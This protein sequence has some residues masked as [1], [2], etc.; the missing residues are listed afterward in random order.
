MADR[1]C[2]DCGDVMPAK[3]KRCA[4]GW[5]AIAETGAIVDRNHQRCAWE[6]NGMRCRYIGTW[7]RSTLG[8]GP[9]FCRDHSG[10]EDGAFGHRILE[11]SFERMPELDYT[12]ENLW[13]IAREWYLAGAS[14]LAGDRPKN[15]AG[16]GKGKPNRDWARR[17]MQRHSSGERMPSIALEF[18]RE[19]L[20]VIVDRE[21]ALEREAIMA[22]GE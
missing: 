5:Q 17:V 6:S 21:A 15:L 8:G 1:H 19:V 13:R 2:P 4:C 14:S 9:Y 7:S 20:C 16:V 18:A 12:P 22:E 10:C 3:A 11:E